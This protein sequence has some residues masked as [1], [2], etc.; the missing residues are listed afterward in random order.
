MPSPSYIVVR[1]VPPEPVD[2]GTFATYL[3]TLQL[4]V[5][6]SATSEPL[7]DPVSFSPVSI[8]EWPPGEDPNLNSVSTATTAATPYSASA[9]NYGK[10]LSFNSVEG[11]TIGAFVWSNND[12]SNSSPAIPASS[13]I[14][15]IA[16]DGTTTPQTVTLSQELTSYVPLGTPVSFTA[17]YTGENPNNPTVAAP[18]FSINTNGPATK[19]PYGYLVILPLAD[20]TGVVAGM[21]VAGTDVATGTTVAEVTDTTVTL[22]QALQGSTTPTSVKF[23]LQTPFA[24]ISLTPTSSTTTQLTFGSGNQATGV[25]VG[26][27]LSPGGV[28]QPGTTVTKATQ[29]TVN[30]LPALTG[31]LPTN[32]AV[33]FTFPLG[34]GIVQHYTY[35]PNITFF[36]ISIVAVPAAVATA[37]IPLNLLDDQPQYL[38]IDI[39]ASRNGGKEIIPVNN[40]YYNVYYTSGALPPA[41]LYQTIPSN[42]TSLYITL[43][44]QPGTTAVSLTIPNDGS[45]PPFDALYTAM[46]TALQNDPLL[47]T[48]SNDTIP[49]LTCTTTADCPSQTSTLTFRAADVSNVAALLGASGTIGVLFVGGTNIPAGTTVQSTTTTTVAISNPVSADVAAGSNITFTPAATLIPA[50]IASPADCSRMAYDIV[51]SNQNPLPAPPDPLEQLYTNP[52]NTGGS[53]TSGN[54]EPV[55]EQ[56]RQKF[57]GTLNSFYS[58]RNATAER[59]TKFVAAASA[60]VYC[61]Q[62]SL[63]SAAALLE[64]PVDPTT[65]SFATAVES[66]LLLDGLGL[67]GT[68]NINFGVPAAFFYSLGASLDKSTSAAQRY[69]M[70]TG[71]A[72]DRLLQQFAAAEQPPAGEDTGVINDSEAFVDPQFNTVKISSFQA[73]RRLVALG[74]SAASTSPAATLVA[75]SPLAALVNDWLSAT[76]PAVTTPPSPPPNPPQTYQVKDFNIWKYQ[77]AQKDPQ[78]YLELDLDALTQGFIIPEFIANTIG[79]SGPTL[80]V[81][82]SP[83]SGSIGVGM[84]VNGTNI[85]AGTTVTNVSPLPGNVNV[86]ITL[87]AAVLGDVPPNTQI[88]FNP[89]GTPFTGR[90]IADCPSGR[91]LI[92]TLSPTSP[93]IG[94][95]MPVSGTNIANGTTVT[96]IST[97]LP[98]SIAATVTLSGAITGAIT[99]GTSITFNYTVPPLIA[100]TT[101][102]CPSGTTLTFASTQGT[103]GIDSG[104]LVS[105]INIAPGT[106]VQSVQPTP[107]TVTLSAA[108]QGD[109]PQGSIITFVT[110]V[111]PNTIPSTLA[112]QIESWLG[113]NATV[114]TLIGVTAAQ[115]TSFLTNNPSWLPPFTQPVAPGAAGTTTPTTGYIATRI[116]A[117][118]RA[119]QKFFTVS[120]VP[121]AAQLPAPGAPPA[122]AVPAFDPFNGLPSGFNFDTSLTSAQLSAAVSAAV[123]AAFPSGNDP[124]AEAWLSQAITTIDELSQIASVVPNP[125]IT[126]FTLPNPVSFGFS[127]V[128]ALYA[129][130]FTNAQDITRLSGNDF[131]ASLAGTVAYD[132]ANSLYTAAETVAATLG[133][134]PSPST[135]PETGGSFQPINPNGTLTN[136]VPPRCISPLGATAYLQELLKLCEAS[137]CEN[138]FAAPASGH[139]TLAAAVTARRGPL[140]SLLASGA[141]LETPLPL[142]DIV[143]ECLEYL[144]AAT[145]PTNGTVYNTSSDRLAGLA[146]CKEAE[147]APDGDR[148]CH[149]PTAIFAA[150]P[151]YSTPATPV[152]ANQAVEPLVYNNLKTDFSSC[153]LP[154]SQA[155]DVSRTYLR[156]LGTSR[157]EQARVFRKCIT[158]FALDP[159]NPPSDFQSH[160]WRYPVRIET[161]IEYLGISPEEYLMLFRGTPPQPCGQPLPDNVAPAAASIATSVLYGFPAAEQSWVEQVIVLPEFLRRTCLTY[162]EFLELWKA[163]SIALSAADIS[164]ATPFPDCEPCCLEDYRLPFPEGQRGEQI[165]GQLAIF[166]RLWRKLKHECHADY[167]FT[168]LFDISTVLSLFSA[169]QV[170]PEFIR[171]L[172]AFQ[173]LRERFDLPLLDPADETAG[174]TGADRTHLLA[175]WVGTSAT[176]W[177]W[178]VDRLL[179]GVA[180]HARLRF[181]CEHRHGERI[182][183]IAGDLDALSRLAGFNPP[184]ATNPS[185]DTW[186]SHPTCTLRFAEVLAKIWA[187]RFHVEELLHL[188]NGIT[189]AASGVTGSD[190]AAEEA[191]SHPFD[192]EEDD[193]HHS[194]WRLREALLAVEVGEK[195]AIEWTWPRIVTEMRTHFGYAPPSG[196]DPLFSIGQHFFPDVL[197]ASGFSVAGKQRQ[198]RTAL[199]SSKEW[200][201]PPGSPFQ[202]DA[203]SSELCV[204]LA[205]RDEAVATKLSQLPTLTGAEQAAVQD[206][207]FAPRVDLASFAFVFPDWQAAEIHLIEEREEHRRWSYFQ[208]HFALAN[209]RRRV[210][211]EH[212]SR[213]VAHRTGCRHEDLAGV[214]GLVL[215]WLLADENNGTPWESDSGAPPTV[216]WSPPAG[217][218]I[219]ALLGLIGTG[220]RGEYQIAQPQN[221]PTNPAAPS[222]SAS[223]SGTPPSGASSVLEPASGSSGAAAPRPSSTALAV[224]APAVGASD[225]DK[226]AGQVVWRDVRGPFT[227]FGHE[228]DVTNSPIPTVLPALGLELASNPLITLH[229]GYA[230]QSSDGRRLGGA[231]A[232]RVRWS[233]ALLVDREGEYAF[234]AGAPTPDG[235]RP[236]FARA[237]KSQWCLTLKRGSRS[238]VVLNHQWPGETG[239]ER[240]ALRLSRGAY[241]ITIEYAQ[242][243]PDFTVASHLH[244]QQTGFQVKYARPDSD[245]FL[246]TLPLSHLYRDFQDNTLDHGIQFLADSKNAQAFL[247]TFYTSTL[248]DIRRTYKR[249]FKA[250]LLCGRFGFSARP[251]AESGQSELGY[252]LANPQ[253]FAGYAYYRTSSTT[254]NTHLAFFDFNFLPVEDSFPPPPVPPDRSQPSLQRT[255]AMFDG[256]FE[257]VF[258]WEVVK[259]EVH[260]RCKGQLWL[261]FDEAL[262]QQSADV[263]PLLRHIGADPRY[264]NLD[265]RFY[266]DQNTPI[267]SVTR[268]DLEDERWLMRVWHADRLVRDRLFSFAPQAIAAARPDF[269]ASLDPSA[270][271]PASGV[272]ETGNANL[273]QFLTYGCLESGE[274]R[275]YQD[276]KQLNDGLRERGRYALVHY[277]CRMNRVS[278][279]YQPSQFATVPRDLGDLLLIEVETGICEAASRIEEATT[280]VQNFIRRSRLGLEP[281]WKVSREF[282]RLWDSRFDTYRVWERCKRRELYR[283]NWIEWDELRKARR[284]AAFSFLESELRNSTLTLAAPG[285]LDWWTNDDESLEFAPTLLQRR[286]P[287]ELHPLSPAPQS[288]TREGLGTLGTPEYAALPTWLARV[289]LPATSSQPTQP[290]PSNPSSP[291]APQAVTLAPATGGTPSQP[292]PL[293]MEAAMKMGTRFLRVAAAGIPPAAQR[294]VPHRD[295]PDSMCCRECDHDHRICMDEYYFW[296]VNTKFYS[297]TDQTDSQNGADASFQGSYQ[298][299]FQDSYYDQWQQLS[300]EWNDEDQVPQLLA[301]W[302]PNPAVR[303]AWC[304]VH[305]GQ[306]GQPRKSDDYVPI[307]NPPDLV[308][309][310]RSADSLYF[311]VSGYASPE[312]PAGYSDTSPPGFR[313]DLPSD[314]AVGLPQVLEPPK[315]ATPSPYPGGLLSYP[316]FAYYEPGASLFPRSW[317]SPSLLV[318]DALRAHCRFELALK[319]YARAFD[320]LKRDCTWMIC[321]ETGATGP[322]GATGATGGTVGTT[323]A[324]GATVGVQGGATGPTGVTVG[325]QG[326]TTPGATGGAIGPVGVA[327]GVEDRAGT[328]PGATGGATEPTGGAAG[329]Q[330]QTSTESPTPSHDQIEVEAYRIWVQHGRPPAEQLA[331]WLEAEAELKAQLPSSGSVP[332]PAAP[333]TAP[334]ANTA[335]A[336]GNT[337][338][339]A[340]CDSTKVSDE[341]VRNRSVTLTFCD[342]ML[343]WAHALMRHPTSP[344]AYQHARLICDTVAKIMGRCP[345][346]VLL[347]E[348]A[349]PEPISSFTPAFP[350][351]NPRLLDLYGVLADR[352]DLVHLCLD[353]RR[354]KNGRPNRDLPYFGDDPSREGWRIAVDVCA[355]ESEW[356]YPTSPYR[357]VFLIQKALEI[358]GRVRELGAALLAAYEKGD[359]EYLAALRAGQERDLLALGLAIRQ[360]QWRDADW[361]V[362]VLQQTKDVSQT[363]LLY[364]TNLYQ[365]GLI[366]YEILNQ[367]LATNAMQTRTAANITEAFGEAMKVIPDIFVGFCSSDSQ[368]PVG[369]KLAGVFETIAKVMQTI[370]DVQAETAAIDFTQAGWQRRSDEWFHQTVT[371][372]I[373]IQEV[374][375]QILGAHRRRDQALQELNNQQRQIEQAAEVQDFLRDKF[376][377]TDLYL[378]LQKQT[379]ALYSEMYQLAL[380]SARQAQRAFNFERG[381][382]TRHF[383]P[384][385]T[386]D[387]LHDGLLA[388]EG[389]DLA[390]HR[391]EK[392][393]YDENVREYELTKHFS[394]RLHFP[395]AYLQL[396]TTGY[397][398]IDIPEWMFEQDYPSQYMRRIRNVSL[399]IPCITGPYTG[400][401]CRLTLL[402]SKIRIDPRLSAPPH[403]C[404]SHGKLREACQ[405]CDE[406]FHVV[407]QYGAREAIATSTGQNDAGLLELNFHDE[408]YLP[409]EF[410][411]AVS[412]WRIELPPENN[413][414]QL[415]TV[416]D[417]VLNLNYTAREGG[418]ML[419]HKAFDCARRHLPGDGWCFFDLRHDFPD[420]WQLFRDQSGHASEDRDEGGRIELRLRRDM[421]PFVP[422]GPQIGICGLGLLFETRD[423][424]ACNSHIVSYR[425][426]GLNGDR[427]DPHAQQIKCVPLDVE[428]PTFYC[429]M[430]ALPQLEDLD[431]GRLPRYLVLRFPEGCGEIVR[432][433]LLCRYEAVGR[434]GE[435][436]NSFVR[437]ALSRVVGSDVRIASAW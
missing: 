362:Q 13:G 246:V 83:S 302:Q 375:L 389:L 326:G 299:G 358:T 164:T 293:W 400:V 433:F 108:V 201:T 367:T 215:S 103:S 1:L 250:V 422:G 125:A 360:D 393:Y 61:E 163:I 341:V 10:V 403:G 115:W 40:P 289:P 29:T 124:A 240:N 291:A 156:Y 310:G 244:P 184:T 287:S 22:S 410:L 260:R 116:R 322:T 345:P 122:F 277:L 263:A 353:A 67:A 179:E 206:L 303:L 114:A 405:L 76:D 223:S 265:L 203:S 89:T 216:M 159:T 337:G 232:F 11:I 332:T 414:F 236:D 425:L 241:H 8:F 368:V 370:A 204:Q 397:C 419:R 398:E 162:C 7:S 9:N 183:Y 356:C 72:I 314:R 229:N 192:L 59:L 350:S 84:P 21:A 99:N 435:R 306:F 181:G 313:Y 285:G 177:Q 431:Q 348:P 91:T 351:L 327:V 136:C 338:Q 402:S 301:K 272:S 320:P 19:D 73:A 166:I 275:R 259:A 23:T 189:E 309:L 33:V 411:G 257:R 321:P 361:Q 271:V 43:P 55:L 80:T 197:E 286:T 173:M 110:P 121:T 228:R 123:S 5:F 94:V 75:G 227:T 349:I 155:L 101:A 210:I 68:S 85:G 342:T 374:E 90:T 406:E 2:G 79:A 88:T 69:Q 366:N 160:L 221:A 252:R 311:S 185:T 330:G 17:Q 106:T 387:S 290:A 369:T 288:T 401:H 243:A 46:L 180:S 36:D 380:H 417:L 35:Y 100:T 193:D 38:N 247:K 392:A 134:A 211:A 266:Q 132:F 245:G 96:V 352:M 92:V 354:L 154:Y 378:W 383:I 363:N 317:F 168:E 222:S 141:N 415:D 325:V 385:E 251:A 202:Y 267:Y 81:S 105:G 187:S 112:D 54:N 172:A 176:K 4:Q 34:S 355:D 188:F 269:W 376:T 379:A 242:P 26:M 255:Q 280:A 234:H 377:A 195:E 30:F 102:D 220:L 20:T 32:E 278:L 42:D 331:D 421:F 39:I 408:R 63:Y 284:S 394:L 239:H 396:R 6:D 264:W 409:F 27:T 312:P 157:F 143:N 151:E 109:V 24:A 95:G 344:E 129:R 359:A 231:E 174:A 186:N 430:L 167:S 93:N 281:S 373:E 381:H 82:I 427:D 45:P 16:V 339:S 274:P 217:G 395:I 316:F 44:P 256:M 346:T 149:D 365:N 126:G 12:Q 436:A 190:P 282:A 276:L 209:A 130:G 18:S 298:F 175:L 382:T 283:E 205:L 294:F 333:G 428:R 161:A 388:G 407:R 300:A 233:G 47:D 140:G 226:T 329:A 3:D 357:F 78:G 53:G 308:F 37:V 158:E 318:G 335:A 111:P 391:M 340:C 343:E 224:T 219:A 208:H 384:E 418:E 142:I 258:D 199:T 62:T 97:T 214:A 86:T 347:P 56:D 334:V 64:F 371:L 218:A 307:A 336:A 268:T 52:P 225:D 144:G 153:D 57:Q 248:R 364:Y 58:T 213:H 249:A 50:L 328:A 170:N 165:L 416:T 120:S 194:L 304:R 404:C 434:G 178:A 254:F 15:V 104:M 133:I 182:A 87:S 319:W 28:I 315:P 145:D 169:G 14:T 77:L 324:T 262:L 196:Q 48:L 292:L 137:T 139:E 31:T 424:H 152:T 198:Y 253:Q 413:Y 150:L 135:T 429:G 296:L 71:D 119:V 74:I 128:E 235:E 261:L 65:A 423:R 146:L 171:Q 41:Y 138:P 98:G 49:A 131:Q 200:N 273:S 426:R 279:P 372:P 437:P 323:G 51:W 390:L 118:I 25:A 107:H 238:W 412:R 117:F 270:P 60:A 207:Y 113:A 66:E 432:A 237:E 305:N 295:E 148:R 297:Y 127:L 386:W 147:P 212:L 191:L 70:A 420:A 399:T 230:V